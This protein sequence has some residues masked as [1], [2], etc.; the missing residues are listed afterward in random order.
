MRT[1]AI[2]HVLLLRVVA[3]VDPLIELQLVRELNHGPLLS[4]AEGPLLGYSLGGLLPGC[5]ALGGVGFLMAFFAVR[6]F[7]CLGANTFSISAR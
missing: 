6:F 5:F 3:G 2:H 4:W 7:A 1:Q